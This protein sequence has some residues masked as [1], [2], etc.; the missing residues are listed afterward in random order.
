MVPFLIMLGCAMGNVTGA[1]PL[2]FVF[3]IYR[4]FYILS[5][6]IVLIFCPTSHLEISYFG[7]WWI[8]NGKGTSYIHQIFCLTMCQVF[9]H[10]LGSLSFSDLVTHL[11]TLGKYCGKH[12]MKKNHTCPVSLTDGYFISWFQAN[13]CA[14]EVSSQY[15]MFL[16]RP[17][18]ND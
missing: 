15:L 16:W 14:L 2:F 13:N 18:Q 11:Y 3:S 7:F 8:L 5:W 9:M 10:C 12:S 6:F 17:T 1:P 4:P